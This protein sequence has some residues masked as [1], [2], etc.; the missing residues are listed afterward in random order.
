MKFMNDVQ[1][2]QLILDL[3]GNSRLFKASPTWNAQKLERLEA[4]RNC[5]ILDLNTSHTDQP[6]LGCGRWT[7]ITSAT[8]HGY[9]E[10]WAA[11]FKG[12]MGGYFP[13]ALRVQESDQF[14]S[15]IVD[16]HQ[17]VGSIS[18]LRY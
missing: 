11:F 2:N 15:T 3:L 4:A 13:L 5:N 10:T 6:M 16:G 14:A 1:F 12:L 7:P 18:L 8:S 9:F 17:W